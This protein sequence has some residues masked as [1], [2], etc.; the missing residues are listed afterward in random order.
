[1]VGM[2]SVLMV[3]G[4]IVA[5][6]VMALIV[7]V[8]LGKN[9]GIRS[10]DFAQC[11]QSQKYATQNPPVSNQI[12]NGGVNNMLTLKL[13]GQVLNAQAQSTKLRRQ[14]LSAS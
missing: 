11:V 8:R 6:M 2:V 10:R 13:N 7:L 1:M 4:M 14:I 9:A 5:V 12:T 3:V